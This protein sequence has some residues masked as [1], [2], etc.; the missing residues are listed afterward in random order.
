ME[1]STLCAYNERECH[2]NRQKGLR[3]IFNHNYYIRSSIVNAER[4]GNLLHHLHSTETLLNDMY[5]SY[6]LS[7][8]RMSSHCGEKKNAQPFHSY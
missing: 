3:W 2:F 8:N 6:Y 1:K 5:A 4:R 7:S